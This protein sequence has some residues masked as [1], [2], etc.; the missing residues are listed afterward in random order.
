MVAAVMAMSK[1]ADPPGTTTEKAIS[2]LVRGELHHQRAAKRAKDLGI[3]SVDVLV[4]GPGTGR[5]SAIRAL[6]SAGLQ[7]LTIR[8]TARCPV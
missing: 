6:A 8:E 4:K 1:L 7:V 5:E 3:E 2:L